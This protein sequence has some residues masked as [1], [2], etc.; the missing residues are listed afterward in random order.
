MTD[1]P[2]QLILTRAK[3]ADGSSSI[4]AFISMEE[5]KSTL[6]Y[7]LM[8]MPDTTLEMKV[9]DVVWGED[10]WITYSP[11]EDAIKN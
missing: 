1:T 6:K 2:N 4:N 7:C 3:H 5:A 11:Y 10:N 9:V 8:F